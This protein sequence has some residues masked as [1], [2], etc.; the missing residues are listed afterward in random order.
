MDLVPVELTVGAV[1]AYAAW[2]LVKDWR[3]AWPTPRQ[4]PIVAVDRVHTL[5]KVDNVDMVPTMVAPLYRLRGRSDA[6]ESWSPDAS[7]R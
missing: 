2:D 4:E 7:S 3:P 1:L 6:W 5:N